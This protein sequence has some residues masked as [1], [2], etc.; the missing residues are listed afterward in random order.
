MH[1]VGLRRLFGDHAKNASGAKCGAGCGAVPSI[2]RITTC[3]RRGTST[4]SL[5]TRFTSTLG[6]LPAPLP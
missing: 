5:I 1:R 2:G 4:P 3:S 6:R